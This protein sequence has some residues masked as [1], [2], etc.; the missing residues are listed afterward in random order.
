[1]R[2]LHFNNVANTGANLVQAINR[3][4][5]FARLIDLPLPSRRGLISRLLRSPARLW[6]WLSL[7][8]VVKR[9]E[10][11]ILHLH[12]ATVSPIGLL[13]QKPYVVHC[14]GTDIRE[15]IHK[16]YRTAIISR[17][18]KKAAAVLYSTPDLAA[19]VTPFRSD[20][21]FLPNPV[22]TDRFTPTR[23]DQTDRLKILLYSR[24]SEIKGTPMAVK[25]LE[26][27]YSK[28]PGI[29]IDAIEHGPLAADIAARSFISMIPPVPYEDVPSLLNKYDIVVGQFAL[30]ICSMAELEA[31]SSAKP[32]IMNSVSSADHPEPIALFADN[33]SEIADAILNL[34]D[35]AD[36]RASIG[37][38]AHQYVIDNH[39]LEVTRDRLSKIYSS[40]IPELAK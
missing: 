9:D 13:S 36:L 14:H 11:D 23:S 20:A 1:M 17:S 32:V 25:G 6:P 21:Q 29:Q 28:L 24:P 19:H 40:I 33:P 27:A 12:F 38:A 22:D 8:Y 16:W 4:P 26:I 2:I 39:S 18:L 15:G 34:S 5:D 31:M 7:P 37:A 3:G 30:G 35:D 10:F